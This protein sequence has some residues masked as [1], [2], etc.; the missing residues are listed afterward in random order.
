MITL[1]EILGAY[2]E[3][4]EK[5]LAHLYHSSLIFR[6]FQKPLGILDLW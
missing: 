4:F 3:S 2:K 6:N 5:S 1:P